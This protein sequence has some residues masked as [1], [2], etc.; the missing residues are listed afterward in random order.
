MLTDGKY[1]LGGEHTVGDTEVEIQH[2]TCNLH[3]VIN[4]CYFNKEGK[5][6]A[7]EKEKK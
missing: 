5:D 6:K 3:N 2:C 1:I 7:Q 4:H